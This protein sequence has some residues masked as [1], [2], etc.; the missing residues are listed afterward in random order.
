VVVGGVTVTVA[1]AL[2]AVSAWDTAVTVTVLGDG[3]V[4]GAVY[5]PLESMVPTVVFPPAT[6]F[7]CQ[8]T[9]V[10]LEKVTDAV[11][12]CVEVTATEVLEGLTDIGVA[13]VTV[14]SA[15][16]VVS[17]LEITVMVTA[18]GLGIEAGAVYSP[19]PDM[20]PCVV[21]PPVTPFTCQIT[22][23]FLVFFTVAVNCVVDEVATVAVVGETSTET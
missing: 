12:C 21:L 11:N 13:T 3:T 7:T 16:L 10:L 23:V 8:L 22:S 18:A 17:A 20:V 1:E 6:P 14:A 9:A 15:V 19:V 2:R 5:S 4:L